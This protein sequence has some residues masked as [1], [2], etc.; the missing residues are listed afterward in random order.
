MANVSERPFSNARDM[1]SLELSYLK[2]GI[3]AL[4]FWHVN[5]TRAA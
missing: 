3:R 1:F 2:Q 4:T 5:A